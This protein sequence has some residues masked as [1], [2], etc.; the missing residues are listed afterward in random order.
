MR[1]TILLLEVSQ[2]TRYTRIIVFFSG[3]Y[4]HL[5]DAQIPSMSRPEDALQLGDSANQGNRILFVNIAG[6]ILHRNFLFITGV[7]FLPPC[8]DRFGDRTLPGRATKK[9]AVPSRREEQ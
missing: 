4:L 1:H 5:S 7:S 8:I 3:N 2:R 6:R 9:A